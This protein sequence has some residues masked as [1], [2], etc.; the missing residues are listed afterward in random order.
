M[1]TDLSKLT[2]AADRW[3]GMA[4]EFEKR[5]K[6]YRRD[7]HG[8]S[9]GTS[10]SGLSADAANQR[11]NTTLNEFRSAQT[12]AKAIAGLLRDAHTNLADLTGKL[13]AARQEAI[14]AKMNVSD[15]GVV[16]YDYSTLTE[17]DKS[18]L[19][20]DPDYQD[21]IRKAVSS[22]QDRIDHAVQAVAD[23]DKGIEIAFGAVVVDS[24]V[25]DG[26]MG[27][28]FNGRAQGD[29]EK[30]EAEKVADIATRLNN[31]EMISA[32]D[33]SE[34]RRSFRDNSG[35]KAFSHTLLGTL[36]PDGT[37]KLTNSLDRLAYDSDKKN[38]AQYMEL[39]G[40]LAETLATA[41][42]VPGSVKD[43]PPG[44]KLFNTW[45]AS[46][47]GKF[48]R[49][50]MEGIDKYGTQNYGSKT[51]PLY[52]YQSLVSMMEHSGKNYDDQFLY[53]L[54]DDLIA[55]EKAHPGIFTEWGAGH[56]GVRAD[57]VD[58]LLGVM[59][60]NPAAATAFFDPAGNGSGENH[61]ANNHLHYLAGSGDGTRD[62]P[63]H[64]LTGYTV[65]ETD[66]PLS[67][68]GLGAALEAAATGHPPLQSGQDP[69]PETH[70]N[71]AQTRVMHGIIEE[72]K[73]SSGTDAP[74]P[75]HLR[76][77]I[78]HALAEYTADTHEILGGLDA[79][80]IKAADGD[81]YFSDGKNTHLAVSQK[82]LVQVMRG[83]SEDPDAYATLD[84]AETRHINNELNKLPPGVASHDLSGPLSKSGAALGTF[85]AIREDV[86]NDGRVAKYGEADWKAKVAY[87][88]IGGA[89]TPLYVSTAGGMTIAVG[90]SL[91]RGVDTWAWQWGNSMKA[92]ADTT[93]NAAVADFYL[94]SH[95]RMALMV[96]GW[97]AGRSD[98]DTGS[99]QAKA[100]V[101]T[102]TNDIL[103]G[104]DRGANEA[105][106]YLTDTTN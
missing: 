15:Q 8:I 105:S 28:G 49:Q 19:H 46:E 94:N 100:Q 18:A 38:K 56:D 86:V 64:V 106:K 16:S 53:Q 65:T 90:D 12:E 13:K 88:I 93:A 29:I 103:N 22:W 95:N 98:M 11:F 68:T 78:S 92:E 85:S 36:G 54:G 63:K 35:D 69:W 48:Y 76:Q 39:E 44:S 82:D 87:H 71:E 10:W 14:S 20:H 83:L 80:Y 24:N 33:L 51:N 84:K 42:N 4:G 41:T 2:S 72:L 57:A 31:G 50:W 104:S 52:G 102:L 9:M 7:V 101:Q 27:T 67:R 23:A 97:A 58:G 30:Y 37:I 25:T 70:H 17:S 34:L 40:G 66:D 45:I 55:S 3:D 81:G 47:D 89:L 60:R 96:D 77:P 43:A 74:V 75:D 91:Q 32:T 59:S 61:I 79:E 26:T 99:D 73:P 6:A 1:S 62:W 21:S 5:E